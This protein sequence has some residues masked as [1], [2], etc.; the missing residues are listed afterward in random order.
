MSFF[1]DYFERVKVAK[2]Y[3]QVLGRK[4][5]T[6]EVTIDKSM[7]I[8]AVNLRDLHEVELAEAYLNAQSNMIK[9][10]SGEFFADIKELFP[11]AERLD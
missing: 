8:Y 5:K 1:D 11:N 10:D 4:V 2:E 7:N 3:S 6:S 9:D